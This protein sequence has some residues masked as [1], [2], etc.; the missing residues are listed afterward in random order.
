[1]ISFFVKD[2]HA[3]H[4]HKIIKVIRSCKN[5]EQLK[6]AKEWA[7]KIAV[8]DIDRGIVAHAHR[9]EWLKYPPRPKPL[10][11]SPEPIPFQ[12]TT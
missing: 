1:M 10:K 11:V 4:I 2:L 3:F 8:S 9:I 6:I 12:K 5:G 7:D